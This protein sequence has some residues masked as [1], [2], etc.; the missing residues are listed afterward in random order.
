[1][2]IDLFIVY[3]NGRVPEIKYFNRVKDLFKGIMAQSVFYY[4][5]YEKVRSIRFDG[6]NKPLSRLS[7]FTLANIDGGLAPVVYKRNSTIAKYTGFRG[8]SKTFTDNYRPQRA[9]L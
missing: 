8:Q 9:F 5:K 2:P 4:R 1:M 7:R 6:G 3:T